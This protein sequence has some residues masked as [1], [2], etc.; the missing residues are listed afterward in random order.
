MTQC[1]VTMYDYMTISDKGVVT[2]W[3]GD[4][5][6]G[7]ATLAGTTH[8]QE[9]GCDEQGGGRGDYWYPFPCSRWR[10]AHLMMSSTRRIISAASAALTRTCS[11]LLYDSRTPRSH[12]SPTVPSFMFRPEFFSPAACMAL[13]FVTSSLESKPP[14]SAIMVGNWRKALAKD[15]I[16]R[17]A[18]PAVDGTWTREGY[19]DERKSRSKSIIG[20][21]DNRR[22]TEKEGNDSVLKD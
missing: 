9:W 6:P 19:T 12:M 18:L 8:L 11:L 13:K 10:G 4:C 21:H 16:A 7:T 3:R 20:I 17:A 5:C 14:L 22:G 1:R 2:R 15:S